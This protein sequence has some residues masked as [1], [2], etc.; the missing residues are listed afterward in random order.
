MSL[1]KEVEG[2]DSCVE[3]RTRGQGACSTASE[4]S[5]QRVWMPGDSW[6]FPGNSEM[7]YPAER[8]DMG[9]RDYAA[10]PAWEAISAP[11]LV[12]LVFPA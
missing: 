10:V 6:C 7:V 3:N 11:V 4:T 2:K 1:P 8:G 5:M 12:L 9:L